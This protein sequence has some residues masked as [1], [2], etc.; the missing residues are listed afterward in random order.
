MG[1]TEKAASSALFV[2]VL[3]PAAPT[4]ALFVPSPALSRLMPEMDS[5]C[6]SAFFASDG[7]KSA[8]GSAIR[9]GGNA[10]S[11]SGAAFLVSHAVES[12]G[13]STGCGSRCSYR[14]GQSSSLE[15]VGRKGEPPQAMISFAVKS[16]PKVSQ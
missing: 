2:P 14:L 3:S 15:E 9:G 11:R 1:Q 8:G 16:P 4:A 5:A 6:G 7:T 12:G 13:R 10:E